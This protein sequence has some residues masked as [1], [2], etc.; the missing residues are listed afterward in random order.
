MRVIIVGCGRVGATVATLLSLRGDDVRI[1]DSD[2]RAFRRLDDRFKGKTFVGD[3]LDE[4]FLRQVG[5]EEMEGFIATTD[6]DNRNIMAAQIAK[7]K[8]GINNIIARVYDPKRAQAYSEI[9]LHVIC[10][11]VTESEMII[12]GLSEVV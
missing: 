3:G 12:K 5:I 9:G 1:V 8:F 7:Q 11:T 2:V 10:P 6:K 4:D